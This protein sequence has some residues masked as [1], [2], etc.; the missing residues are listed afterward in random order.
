MTKTVLA[1]G[2]PIPGSRIPD[3][4]LS[5]GIMRLQSRDLGIENLINFYVVITVSTLIVVCSSAYIGLLSRQYDST[6]VV[7]CVDVDP[8]VTQRMLTSSCS[9]QTVIYS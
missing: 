3:N 5:H 1:V 2:I 9:N 7:R 6:C 8:Y 4:F